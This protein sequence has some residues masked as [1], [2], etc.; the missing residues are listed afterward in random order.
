MCRDVVTKESVA[1]QLMEQIVMLL[2]Q[3]CIDQLSSF[4]LRLNV[5][6]TEY[7]ATDV[8]IST[9]IKENGEGLSKK[10]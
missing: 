9:N 1:M 8:S 4:G 3:L 6:K 2:E 7:L 10:H 5:K